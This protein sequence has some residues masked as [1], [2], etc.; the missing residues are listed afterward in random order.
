MLSELSLSML[1]I[2]INTKKEIER[3]NAKETK[4]KNLKTMNATTATATVTKTNQVRVDSSD[5]LF[6]LPFVS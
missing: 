2:Y 1:F 5:H 3:L 4:T 6:L